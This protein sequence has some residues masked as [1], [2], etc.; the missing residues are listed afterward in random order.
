MPKDGLARERLRAAQAAEARA[1]TA[2]CFAE[3][4][5]VGVRRKRDS[6]VAKADA[7]VAKAEQVVAAAQAELV[8]VSGLDRAATLLGHEKVVLRRALSAGGVDG[9]PS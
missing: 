9:G 5:L 6:A 4:V 1:V 2:V 8:A 3:D 7:A